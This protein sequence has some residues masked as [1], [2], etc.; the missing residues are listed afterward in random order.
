MPD[1]GGGLHALPCVQSRRLDIRLRQPA[2]KA[3]AG[4]GTDGAGGNGPDV[5]G[6]SEAAKPYVHML[7]STLTATQRTMCCLLENHQ[8]GVPPGKPPGGC[9]CFLHVGGGALGGACV[10][11]SSDL[12]V[13]VA[14]HKSREQG[15]GS[16][17]QRSR[18]PT[19][20][21]LVTILPKP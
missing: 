13:L 2:R 19:N 21:N 7:N 17:L 10:C 18:Q 9:A 3:G 11:V 4:S 12:S 15:Q 6:G 20:I 5:G 1:M 16:G 14:A 8:V